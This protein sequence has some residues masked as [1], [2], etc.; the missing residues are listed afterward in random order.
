MPDTA[1]LIA[2]YHATG[3]R[4]VD[5]AGVLLAESRI[6][7]PS[8]SVDRLL[9]AHG[10]RSA[11][12][13]TAWNPRSVARSA[14]DNQAAHDRLVAD[15]A[16]RGARFLPHIGV[17]AD[18]AWAEHGAF[19]LDFATADALALALAY[20]QNAIVVAARGEPARLVLTLLMAG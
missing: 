2:A 5:D 9:A 12:F 10:A 19:V 7:Q 1:E 3:Y 20:E 14:R 4:V 18:P 15:L 6:G 13:I 16:D 8:A 11:V 17:G